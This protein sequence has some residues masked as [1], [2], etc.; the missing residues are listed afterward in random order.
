VSKPGQQQRRGPPATRLA[1]A[2]QG[3]QINHAL[4]QRAFQKLSSNV[5]AGEGAGSPGNAAVI[6]EEPQSERGSRRRAPS[7]RSQ[8]RH[9]SHAAVAREAG[10]KVSSNVPLRHKVA[11]VSGELRPSEPIAG[12]PQEEQENGGADETSR[13][14]AG[15]RGAP[16]KRVSAQG[17]LG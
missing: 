1:P 4:L 2:V 14:V 3:F 5:P 12:S 13:E 6:K 7:A 16:S 17:T 10:L 11:E 8:A 9:L 15:P